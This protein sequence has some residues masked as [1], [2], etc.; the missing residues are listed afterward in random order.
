[1]VMRW[2]AWLWELFMVDTYHKYDQAQRS[3]TG[4]EC[5]KIQRDLNVQTISFE[6][7]QSRQRSKAVRGPR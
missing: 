7:N 3:A 2:R 4:K 5:R 6:G 1:M